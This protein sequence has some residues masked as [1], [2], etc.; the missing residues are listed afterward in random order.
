MGLDTLYRPIR[1]EDV[2]GQETTV[3]VLRSVVRE[4]S[5]FRQSYV[6][7]GA[8]GSG[9]TTLARILAR[10]LLCSEPQDGNPCDRCESCES[11]LAAGGKA[12]DSFVEVDAANHSGKADIGQIREDVMYSSFSGRRRIYL[13][14]EAHQLSSQ[15]MDALLLL[16]EEPISPEGDKRLVCIFCTTELDKMREAILSRCAPSFR[17]QTPPPEKVRDRLA[18]VAT[19]EGIPFETEALSLVA[20][21][22]ECH[23]R[24]SL[25]ALEAV[26]K[27]GPVTVAAVRGALGLRKTQLA[28]EVLRLIV[29]TSDASL[30]EAGQALIRWCGAAV[31]YESTTEAALLA[32]QSSIGIPLGGY[33]WPG[34]LLAQV[35]KAGGTFLIDVA[36]HLSGRPARSSATGFLCDI[37]HLSQLKRGGSTHSGR[38]LP[39]ISKESSHGAGSVRA[40]ITQPYTTATGV[41]VNPAARRS[42]QESS[43]DLSPQEFALELKRLIAERN[44]QSGRNN[45]G[46]P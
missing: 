33:M 20:E 26:S 28:T 13:F 18:Y 32:Y 4:G 35:G 43:K 15:A 27:T 3:S 39:S 38:T 16:L 9:K 24:N 11:F 8:Y 45:M 21:A 42:K 23:L 34:D 25:K 17:V 29:M 44:G 46:H 6:F 2:V 14:D 7:A 12:H 37:L 10:A 31:A 1:F 41:F 40:E 30:I 22:T 19:K 5:G 36:E